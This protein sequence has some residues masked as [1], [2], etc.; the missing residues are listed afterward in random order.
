[1]NTATVRRTATLVPTMAD[2]LARSMAK[3]SKMELVNALTTRNSYIMVN[4]IR[5]ILSSVM[6]EDGSGDSFIL[7]VYGPDNNLYKCYTR[8]A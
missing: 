3:M 1:M 2:R 7:Q 5:C 4:G 6:R 8:A